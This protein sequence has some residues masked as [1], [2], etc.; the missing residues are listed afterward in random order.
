MLPQKSTVP[1][2]AKPKYGDYFDAWNSSSTGHQ[3]AENKLG[4]S[5]GWRQS[6]A[7]KLSHQFKSG[8][9]GG[10]RISDKVGAGS[11]DWDENAKAIIHKHVRERAKFNVGD[12]L[13]AER[14]PGMSG[15]SNNISY[16]VKL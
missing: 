13:M 15:N 8:G 9:T 6:R 1:L 16:F 7:M 10:K 3:R 11:E 4:G 14:G 5:T 12:M 2:A